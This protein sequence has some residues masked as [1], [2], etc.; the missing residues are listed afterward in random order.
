[1]AGS[2]RR[3][4]E[5]I[6]DLDL[7]AVSARPERATHALVHLPQAAA[8]LEAGG[9]KAAIRHREGIQVDLRVVARECFGAA[10]AYFT[11]SKQHNIR[12]RELGVKRGLRISEYGVFRQ[13][14][15]RRIAGA[16]EEEVYAT[17]GLPWI[18]PELREDAGEVEAAA[19]GRLPVLV[20]VEDIHGDLHCHTKA[21]DGQHTI[22]ALVQAARARGYEYVAVTDHSVSATVAHG[23][24]AGALRAHVRRIRAAGSTRSD[25]ASMSSPASSRHHT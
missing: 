12:V 18:P 15:D 21:S 16:T 19:A 23:L 11:G 9:T 20:R 10:L 3:R 2:I 4:K 13:K 1:M 24:T 8:V 17:V 22:D 6:G 5:T 14:T 7:L 25:M